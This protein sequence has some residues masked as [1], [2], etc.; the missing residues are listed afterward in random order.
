MT[1]VVRVVGGIVGAVIGIW[2]P[3]LRAPS[4][5]LLLGGIQEMLL[6]K[7]RI[8]Q[9]GDPFRDLSTN[10]SDPVGPLPI[11]Y[12]VQTVGVH[13]VWGRTEDE[14]V[15]G[16]TTKNRF[17]YLLCAVCHG[18]IQEIVSVHLDGQL[19][20]VKGTEPNR[21][22][23]GAVAYTHWIQ[24]GFDWYD[25][26]HAQWASGSDG[27]QAVIPTT[28]PR[29]IT[30]I[31]RTGGGGVNDDL[32]LVTTTNHAFQAGDT[33]SVTGNSVAGYNLQGGYTVKSIA[34]PVTIV[35]TPRSGQPVGTGTGGTV[36]H[37][38]MDPSTLAT[39]IGLPWSAAKQGK[40]VAYLLMRFRFDDTKFTGQIPHIEVNVKGRMI[41]DTRTTLT[42]TVSSTAS[43]PAR[44]GYASTTDVTFTS[45]HAMAVGDH[46]YFSGHSVAYLNGYQR[47]DEVVDLDTIRIFTPYSAGTGGAAALLVWSINPAMI[48]RDYLVSPRYGVA[49]PMTELDETALQ[50]EANYCDESVLGKYPETKRKTIASIAQTDPAQVTTVEAA[51][52]LTTGQTVRIW[53]C[54]ITGANG[55]WTATVIDADT[56]SIPFNNVGGGG[57]VTTGFVQV[58][59]TI[60][61]YSTNAVLSPA[62][63]LKTNLEKLMT[64]YRAQMVYQGGVYRTWTRRVAYPS[65][66]ELTPNNII[67][68]TFRFHR[69]GLTEMA[70]KVRA[71][72]FETYQQSTGVAVPILFP[73]SRPDFVE[74]PSAVGY[75]N[76]ELTTEDNGFESMHEI[77][78]AC[79]TDPFIAEQIAQIVRAESRTGLIVGLTVKQDALQLAVGDVVPVTHDTPQWNRK[80]FWVMQIAIQP[81]GLVGLTLLE[82][83]AAAYTTKWYPD[84]V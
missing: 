59:R 17:L 42:M 26:V 27:Q 25:A 61:R 9:P 56:F 78:L 77:D 83:S 34:G 29:T 11:I 18:P 10:V 50:T 66:F 31:Q 68:G 64:A 22:L 72:Y 7:P 8:S 84:E 45:N 53:G 65:A 5:A 57:P 70:N 35:L 76:P 60:A 52:D 19:A 16:V 15:N 23:Q 4:I 80:K 1:K 13:R 32:S 54:P 6:K 38:N 48:A 67:P 58:A 74:W 40:G 47:V 24:A 37:Y 36:D 49:T 43:G 55:T 51:H 63:S 20:L 39:G 75:T 82:Y 14:T 3:F 12:G 28:N 73:A 30:S 2:V 69:P 33:I 71:A 46:R 44:T 41:T 79:T 62:E 21:F 81:D